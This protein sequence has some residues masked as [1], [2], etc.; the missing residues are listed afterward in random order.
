LF[1][2]VRKPYEF[3]CRSIDN[4]DDDE[5]LY[6]PD[7]PAVLYDETN[8]YL[9][10]TLCVHEPT[11]LKEHLAVLKWAKDNDIWYCGP[12]TNYE[13]LYYSIKRCA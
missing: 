6:D 10:V 9:S 11:E 4:S 12:R 7:A 1:G 3:A 2:D 13:R 8:S 5:S